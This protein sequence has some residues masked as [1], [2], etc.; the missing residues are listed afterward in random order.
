MRRGPA[1][2][3]DTI[4]NDPWHAD[5]AE[6]EMDKLGLLGRVRVIHGRAEEVL[7]A[8]EEPYDAVFVDGGRPRLDEEVV[9]LTRLEGAPPG[10]KQELRQTLI[11]VLERLKD[12]L[13]AGAD[14]DHVALAEARRT[15]VDAVRATV[16]G[17]D[18]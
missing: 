16:R 1:G 13:E 17:S 4:E 8:L 15:Y 18:A 9:R 7:P 5:I 10:F 3:V 12:R 14:E 2:H 11:D 6:G